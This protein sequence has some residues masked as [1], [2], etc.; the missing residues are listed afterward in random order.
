MEALAG[1]IVL[2]IVAQW[3][4]WRARIPAIVPLILIGLA[5]GPLAEYMTG[6][7][8]IDPLNE[9]GSDTGL[10]LVDSMFAFVSLAIGIILF[11]GGLTLKYREFKS[12]G[13]SIVRLITL[14]SLITF[15]GG[16]LAAHYIYGLSWQMAFL[17]AALIIVTG[18]TVIAPILRNTPLNRNVA[19]V[20]KWEGIL[21]D[22]VGAL[23]AVLV[24]EF[25]LASSEGGFFQV[26]QEAFITFIKVLLVGLSLGFGAAY[27][28]YYF[29]KRDLIPEYLLNVVTLALVLLVFVLSDHAA[30]E[31]GLLTVVVMGMTLANFKD[32][33]RIKDILDFK[34]SLTVLLISILF[35][36]LAANINLEQIQSLNVT[37]TL[38]LFGAVILLRPLGVFA[39][40]AGTELKTNEKLFISWVGPRGIVAAGVAS[41][42]SLKLVQKGYEGADIITP[43]VFSIVL[44][45]VLL[46]ATTARLMAS[47][48]KVKM[49]KSEGILIIGAN[50]G[51]RLIAQYLKSQQKHVVLID[52]NEQSVEEV[53]ALGLEAIRENIYKLD[54][55]ERFELLDMGYLMAMTSNNNVNEYACK[56]YQHVFG[57]NGT[58]RLITKEEKKKGN[59]NDDTLKLFCS[60]ADYLSFNELA[61][62]F[63]NI[64]EVEIQSQDHFFALIKALDTKDSIPVFV[65]HQDNKIS[66]I[67]SRRE[68]MQVQSG[69]LLVYLGAPYIL[70]KDV[71]IA[72]D[73]LIIA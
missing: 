38:L 16:A 12:V 34:E 13:T 29:I 41:L 32:V 48:L 59:E 72:E 44:G 66:I 70:K 30:H 15:I 65:K 14:G 8:L 69:D 58:Y 21:I 27:G 46:N 1:I 45:T 52:N 50:Y 11:E 42:F 28:L 49:S 39:S 23:A 62:N 51:A 18:P 4:A 20:L 26:S 2:G 57:E 33:P 5:V 6:E 37:N 22:P 73:E 40:T 68:G 35:I 24:F 63:P 17:F 9:G 60:Q 67:A 7:K 36:L 43:I 10:F 53:K 47:W 19:A 55:E 64:H 56:H 31:S 61:H 54:L 71:D 3:V 25:I